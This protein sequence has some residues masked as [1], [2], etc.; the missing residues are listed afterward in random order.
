[1]WIV[2]ASMV[3]G[4]GPDIEGSGVSMRLG[5]TKMRRVMTV[6]VRR[7][8]RTMRALRSCSTSHWRRPVWRMASRNGRS[9]LRSGTTV[10]GAASAR[11]L[12]GASAAA[13]GGLS[14]GG[15]NAST[16]RA[17][18]SSSRGSSMA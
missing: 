17:W 15:L 5:R 9:S 2:A 18:I 14:G 3:S 10:L 6:P 7:S 13:P 12:G 8:E 11:K 4:A 1:M 16:T